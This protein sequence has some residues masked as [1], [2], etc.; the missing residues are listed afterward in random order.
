MQA[1]LVQANKKVQ[2]IQM[3]SHFNLGVHFLTQ[4][5]QFYG[6]GFQRRYH[7]A[8]CLCETRIHPGNCRLVLFDDNFVK[9]A[10]NPSD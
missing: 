8:R 5:E 10:E 2:L 7:Q 6:K 9:M 4:E 1:C 3:L